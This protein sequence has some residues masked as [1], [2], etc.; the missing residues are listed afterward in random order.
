MICWENKPKNRLVLCAV[1]LIALLV[2]TGPVAAQAPVPLRPPAAAAPIVPA[3]PTE[4][5]YPAEAIIN[6]VDATN[7]VSTGVL[8][9]LD[10]GAVGLLTSQNGGFGPEMWRGANRAFVERLLATLPVTTP[11]PTLQKLTQRLLL[12][13][14]EPPLGA[15][16]NG[17]SFLG[18]RLDRLIEA[19]QFDSAGQMAALAGQTRDDALLHARARLALASNDIKFACEMAAEQVKT[20]TA[21]FWLKLAGFCHILNGDDAAAQLSASLAAETDPGDVGYQSLLTALISKSGKLP[22]SLPSLDILHLAMIRF[23][24]LPLPAQMSDDMS[25]GEYKLM[26]RM[27]GAPVEQRLPAAE[28]AEAAG[29]I[30]PEEVLQL[31]AELA[32]SVEDRANARDLAPKLSAAKANALMFQSVRSQDSPASLSLALSAALSL[33]R[34]SNSFA[35]V[36]RVNL[37]PIRDLVPAPETIEVASLMGRALLAAGDPVAARRWYDLARTLSLPGNNPGATRAA[38][39]LWPL[40][41]LAQPPEAVADDPAEISAWLARLTPEEK[42]KKGPLLLSALAA[43]GHATPEAEWIN[44]SEQPE[45]SDPVTMPPTAVLHLLMQASQSGRVG[46][47]VL[48]SLVCLGEQGKGLSHPFLLGLTVRALQAVGLPNEARALALEAALLAGI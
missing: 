30:G 11:S 36:A 24:S 38:N 42:A 13:A 5:R 6:G 35:T 3:A 4:N 28:R 14:A 12:S 7:G 9:E 23:A 37:T 29:A 25:A 27:P 16:S 8:G 26:G 48:L 32:F 19:G 18:L 34:A 31:Y 41:R 2:F 15:T 21:A 22:K 33:A 10:F 39:E 40:L 20:S 47:T 43:L 46:Q 45:T 17:P 44:L 1:P